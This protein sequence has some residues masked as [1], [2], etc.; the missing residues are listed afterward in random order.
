MHCG[1][2]GAL[3]SSFYANGVKVPSL[4]A[5]TIGAEC[6]ATGGQTISANAFSAALSD[7]HFAVAEIMT[8][9]RALTDDELRRAS[10]YLR[11]TVLGHAVSEKE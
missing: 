10:N 2:N 1:T 8:W 4:S 9:N 11:R 7:S 5:T 6:A 3:R